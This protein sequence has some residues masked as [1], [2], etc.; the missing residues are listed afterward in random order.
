MLE[1]ALVGQKPP[2]GKEENLNLKQLK[3]SMKRI[4]SFSSQ[5][6][7]DMEREETIKNI[8]RNNGIKV[9]RT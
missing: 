2:K 4:D 7:A 5:S 1:K 6:S 8:C 9:T 3:N